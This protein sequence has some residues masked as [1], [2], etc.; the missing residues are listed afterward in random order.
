LRNLAT[1]KNP[2]RVL[3]GHNVTSFVDDGETVLVTVQ[4]PNGKESK[5]RTQYLVGSDGGRSIGPKIGVKMEGPTGITDL[6]SV[7]FGADLSE[8][9]DDR[10][11]ACHFVN[12]SCGTIFESGAI[13]PMGPTWGKYNEEWVFHFGFGLDDE[14]RFKEER[15]VPRIR[16]ILK[17]PDLEIKVHKISHWTIERV[18][19]NKY[20]EGRIFIAGDAAHRRPPTTGLGLNTAIEDSLNLAWKLALVLKG[21]AGADILETYEAERRP[22]GRR[23]CDWGLFTFENSAVINAAVGLI[24]GKKEANK[25]RFEAL[26]EESDTG[27]SLRAQVQRM[28][29]SQRIEFSAHDVELGFKYHS[30]FLVPDGTEEQESDPF[31]Q[32]YVPTTRPGNRLPHAWIEREDQ[33]ISTHDLV[34]NAVAFLLITDEEGGDWIS[35]TKKIASEHKVKVVTAQI[36]AAPYLRDYED[37]WEK[38]K[39][40]KRGGAVLARPDN[41]V[42][43]RSLRPSRRSGQELVEAFKILLGGSKGD[44]HEHGVPSRKVNG[45]G[46]AKEEVNGISI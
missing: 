26:F 2:G 29:D 32:V 16:E 40:V 43:W 1:E 24:P 3:F 44:V 35:A 21:T 28:I 34:G 41:I 11:F 7:H 17:I 22:I 12:G 4:D 13:V 42:A 38:V 20:R 19:A 23:N 18:L 25:L 30:G 33:I 8:Y 5:Y 10:F 37:Y 45:H 36:G 14:A 31:G 6:V 15:L 39:G 46:S 9:W 27:R